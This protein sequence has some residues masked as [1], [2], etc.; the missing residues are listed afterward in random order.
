VWEEESG[1]ASYEK[2]KQKRGRNKSKKKEVQ[3][4]RSKQVS[5][6]QAEHGPISRTGGALEGI[7]E[8]ILVAQN[9]E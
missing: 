2:V 9:L 4:S 7:Y 5:G 8:T 3:I 1:R 6:K